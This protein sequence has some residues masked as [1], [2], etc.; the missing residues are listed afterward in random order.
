MG[1][2]T[3]KA[4]ELLFVVDANNQPRE[5][6]PRKS[7]HGRGVW[8]RVSHI[9]LRNNKG[10]VLCQQ[11]SLEKDLNP[12]F[13]E[14]FFGGH[15]EPNETYEAAAIRELREELG[16]TITIGDLQLWKVYKYTDK[17]GYNNEFMGVFVVQWSGDVK[18]LTFDDGEVAQVAWKNILAVKQEILENG[19]DSWTR[20]GYEAD[21]LEE[22]NSA[23][24]SPSI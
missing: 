20:V 2:I 7:V 12:G 10:Q 5:P 23:H 22:L 21:L 19:D 18:G 1:Q 8:H 13:W 3:H 6:L 4:E 16:I 11:R 9:W 14:C 17:K 15:M 24:I